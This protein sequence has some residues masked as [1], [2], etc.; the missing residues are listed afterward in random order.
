MASASEIAGYLRVVAKTHRVKTA[1]CPI[2]VAC[3]PEEFAMWLERRRLARV[4]QP[5]RAS[6]LE[7]VEP[8]S[9]QEIGRRAA[10]FAARL[11]RCPND[12]A[13]VGQPAFPARETKPEVT[14]HVGT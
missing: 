4:A 6:P 5:S 7:Q 3:I 1:G 14:A 9:S 10:A 8:L 12:E 2:A 11:A 13:R